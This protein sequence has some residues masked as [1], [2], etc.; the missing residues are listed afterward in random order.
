MR[1]ETK[2]FI[3]NWNVKLS[4]IKNEE[5][6]LKELYDKFVTMF[7]I[8]NRY[9][10]EAYYILETNNQLQK[11]RYSDYEKATTIVMTFL[12]SQTILDT[13][14]KNGNQ[15]DIDA[16]LDLIGK[17]FNINLANGDPQ[18]ETDKQ[19]IINLKSADTEIKTK[20][21]LSLIYNVRCNIIHGYKDFQEHQRLLVEP[22][23][24]I[25]TSIIGLFK[26]K[27]G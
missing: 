21:V 19:L 22:L 7:T 14:L 8:Y 6:S 12:G 1:L 26:S 18:E 2:D 20:A 17:V 13:L 16:C 24:N 15:N 9:Y 23:I 4:E 5:D 3:E 11:P 25:L 27:L 10:N